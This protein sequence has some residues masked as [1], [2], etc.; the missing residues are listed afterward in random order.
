[1][2][3]ALVVAWLTLACSD[4]QPE[5]AD[6]TTRRPEETAAPTLEVV[7]ATSEA[8]ARESTPLSLG[9]GRSLAATAWDTLWQKR[10]TFDDTLLLQPLQL[11]A[12]NSVL[13]VSDY[14]NKSVQAF[15]AQTG[16]QLW[17]AGRAGSGPREFSRMTLF[18]ASDELLGVSDATNRRISFLSMRGEFESAATV[19]FPG[20]EQG[21][22]RLGAHWFVAGSRTGNARLL[23]WTP[24]SDSL[25]LQQPEWLSYLDTMDFIIA[26]FS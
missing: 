23:K 4:R 13:F 3:T 22:C 25:A 17:S 12:A 19:S 26:Q 20:S 14:G 18:A 9:A 2:V 6:T 5:A 16:E 21:I 8:V 15:D 24:G 11:H 7:E 1:M 10:G